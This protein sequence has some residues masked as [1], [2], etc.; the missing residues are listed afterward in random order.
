MTKRDLADILH[1][2]QEIEDLENQIHKYRAMAEKSTSTITDMP[3]SSKKVDYRDLLVDTLNELEQIKKAYTARLFEIESYIATVDTLFVKRVI[4]YKYIEGLNWRKV[5]E[6]IGGNNTA[7]GV[8]KVLD[9][10]LK[11]K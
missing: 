2:R 3:S 5:A 6:K 10:Y 8:R 7:D 4:R 1:L 11:R 9:R